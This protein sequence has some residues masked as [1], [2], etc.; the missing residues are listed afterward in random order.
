M[1]QTPFWLLVLF[2]FFSCSS[3]REVSTNPDTLIKANGNRYYGGSFH[4]SETETIET[5]FPPLIKDD[6]S[7]RVAGIVFEGL[8]RF[9]ETN[10]NIEP[11]LVKNY[12]IDSLGLTYTFELKDSIYFHDD[13]CFKNGK[14]RQVNSDDIEFCINNLLV[15]V[16]KHNGYDILGEVIQG[17]KIFKKEFLENEETRLEGF[18]KINSQK[19][20]ISLSSP[21][22]QFLQILARPE[23][24]IYPVEA[25][26]KY[27]INMNQNPV[28]TGAFQ[29]KEYTDG[30]SF[31]FRK[32]VNYYRKDDF[33][34]SLPFLNEVVVHFIKDKKTELVDFQKDRLQMIYQL[35]KKYFKEILEDKFE[36]NGGKYSRYI[37][38]HSPEMA[39]EFLG[40]NVSSGVFADKNLRKAISFSIDRAYLLDEV[41]M[42]EGFSPG[43]NGITPPCFEYY[44]TT[45]IQ[46]YQFNID[47]ARYY[48]N[49][50]GYSYPDE[51]PSVKLWFHS[52]GSRNTN[53]AVSI[54]EQVKKAIGM[55]IDLEIV[56]FSK[57]QEKILDGSAEFYRIGWLADIPS[58]E[59]FLSMFYGPNASDKLS[60]PNLGRYKN[61]S[62]DQLYRIAISTTNEKNAFDLFLRAENLMMKDAPVVI[63]WY[64]EGYR[65]LQSYVKNFPNNP[66][67]YRNFSQVYFEK[68][69]TLSKVEM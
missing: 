27:G 44:P 7:G 12:E 49:M 30:S 42:G 4:F 48:L 39:T 33:G 26:L 23:L 45:E 38:Q 58:P 11:S 61:P 59:N 2:L 16:Y 36:D 62:F 51:L 34:N 54:K 69:E 19:F 66:M 56:P 31:V 32:N 21:N 22:A 65:L 52:N 63:L 29:L 13:I 53:I 18:K 43:T 37:L 55:N 5:L 28:G 60:Y 46:G 64:D 6:V 8:F 17:S 67:Q 41:L 57:L 3:E 24:F 35:P 40:F 47:S 50:A 20:Q 68:P 10:L 15:N 14:G 25:Y 1:K 9:N